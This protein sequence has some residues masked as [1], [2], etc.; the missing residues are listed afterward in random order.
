MLLL[1]KS[2]LNVNDFRI[3]FLCTCFVN[4]GNVNY[5]FINNII[6]KS[7]LTFS[8]CIYQWVRKGICAYFSF[9]F[10]RRRDKLEGK[11]S[12]FGFCS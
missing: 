7:V 6:D 9:R 2:H 8:S 12:G 3:I 5:I 4:L 11:Q 10:I 1:Y